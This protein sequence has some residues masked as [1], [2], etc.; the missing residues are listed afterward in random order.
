V[1]VTSTLREYVHRK[2][3]EEVAA[4]GGRY[5]L[6]AETRLAFGGR[7]VLCL[8]GWAAFDTTCCGA[9]GCSYALVP[10]LIVEWKTR[11]NE[12]GLAVSMVEPIVDQTIQAAVR[13]LIEERETVQQVTFL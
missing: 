2:L 3:N 1:V 8:L 13:L 12:E 7:D 5:A 11:W 9:G 4:I 10:G 6:T